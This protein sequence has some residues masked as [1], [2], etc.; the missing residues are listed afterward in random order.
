MR[1]IDADELKKQFST[2][3]PYGAGEIS[4]IIDNAPTVEAYPFE[5]VQE[6]VKLNQ[7]FAQEIENLKRPQG[8]WIP[9]SERWP[10]FTGLYLVS[11]D[12]LVTVANFTGMYFMHRGGWV[13]VDAWMPLPKPYKEGGAK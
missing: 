6:L 9:V 11:I 3:V 7:Q 4:I 1:T 2:D 13:E 12:D 10:S 8:E 5:Q